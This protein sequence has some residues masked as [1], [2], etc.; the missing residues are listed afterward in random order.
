[1][2]RAALA[3]VLV[4]T[5]ALSALALSRGGRAVSRGLTSKRCASA[6]IRDIGLT[7]TN[8]LTAYLEEEKAEV[9][10]QFVPRQITKHFVCVRPE[11][12][13]TPSLLAVSRSCMD[14]IG[15]DLRALENEE[16]R[17][18]LAGV[19]SGNVLAAGLDNPYA[20]N[21]GCHCYGTWFGQLG[22]G[23]AMS[24]GEVRNPETQQS[25]ELQLK[26]CGRTPFS[27]GFDGRAVLRSSV[28]EFLVSESMH[29][30]RVSRTHPTPL[31]IHASLTQP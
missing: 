1:M 9:G 29:H 31:T 18:E 12:V 30:L 17:Q 2:R 24:L 8:T 5:M 25:Y 16:G 21:Y 7:S 10:K 19:L 26:G 3:S 11:P 13:P 27:R 20:V 6:S 15:L 23:R 22:D 4:L 14:A 28:R